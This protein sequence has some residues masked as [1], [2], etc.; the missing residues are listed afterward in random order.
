MV[1][2]ET[3]HFMARLLADGW[4]ESRKGKAWLRSNLAARCESDPF[5]PLGKVF[6]EIRHY[7]LVPTEHNSFN[8]IANYLTSFAS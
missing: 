5:I 4:T 7:G 8:A 6:T 1:G 3:D 2:A